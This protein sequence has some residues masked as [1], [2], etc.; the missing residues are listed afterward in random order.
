MKGK[1]YLQEERTTQETYEDDVM[2]LE[3]CHNL[4]KQELR[5]EQEEPNEGQ[6]YEETAQGKD[7]DSQPNM[8]R[9]TRTTRPVE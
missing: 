2:Q 1:S 7:K 3:Y 4:I 5:E 8:R 9:S 6:E